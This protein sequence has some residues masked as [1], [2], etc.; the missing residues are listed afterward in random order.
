MHIYQFAE[1]T[2]YSANM[3]MNINNNI[4][5]EKSLRHGRGKVVEVRVRGERKWSKREDDCDEKRQW[6]MAVIHLSLIKR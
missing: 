2:L 6:R 3:K 4:N 1:K 5:I